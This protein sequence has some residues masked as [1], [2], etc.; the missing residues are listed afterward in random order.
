MCRLKELIVRK[1]WT[2]AVKWLVVG[3]AHTV[4]MYIWEWDRG[5]ARMAVSFTT[6]FSF[7][8]TIYPFP[9][10]LVLPSAL[11]PLVLIHRLCALTQTE[12]EWGSG[13][14]GCV[15]S[16]LLLCC[17]EGE[18]CE[19]PCGWNTAEMHALVRMYVCNTE[20]VSFSPPCSISFCQSC[21][22]L[23]MVLA[24]SRCVCVA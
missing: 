7:S 20:K 10:C 22:L 19:S 9:P 24:E 23:G 14:R 13:V 4:C 21:F 11:Y 8:L 1:V 5:G 3:I 6:Y 12:D 15:L 18:P 17:E 2:E 16:H